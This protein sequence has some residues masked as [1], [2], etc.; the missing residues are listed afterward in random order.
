VE[1]RFDNALNTAKLPALAEAPG[2]KSGT[3]NRP[4]PIC[5][6]STNVQSW[7]QRQPVRKL[8]DKGAVQVVLVI[9]ELNQTPHSNYQRFSKTVPVMQ[10][11]AEEQG[12]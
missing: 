11:I 4:V 12:R 10:F 1:L 9:G 6:F 3:C 2:L 5:I 7:P 8:S